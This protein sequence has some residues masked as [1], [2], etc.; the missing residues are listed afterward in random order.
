MLKNNLY[1]FYCMIIKHVDNINLNFYIKTNTDRNQKLV[2]S[3]DYKII[4]NNDDNLTTF[5]VLSALIY[6]LL[7]RFV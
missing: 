2:P 7:Q 1:I 3:S 5:F 6:S 4:P